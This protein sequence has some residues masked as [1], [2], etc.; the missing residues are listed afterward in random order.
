MSAQ[1]LVQT[2]TSSKKVRAPRV[3]QQP[4]NVRMEQV[5]LKY[6]L[7]EPKTVELLAQIAEQTAQEL[8]SFVSSVKSAKEQIIELRQQIKSNALKAKVM[9]AYNKKVASTLKKAQKKAEKKVRV[10]LSKEEK[11][12][13]RQAKK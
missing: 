4:L 11:K 1:Q 2:A 6:D 10:A 8:D 5:G 9:K 3:P 13:R 7:E 12:A